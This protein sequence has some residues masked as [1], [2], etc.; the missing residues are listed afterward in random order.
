MYVF[1]SHFRLFPCKFLKIFS[2]FFLEAVLFFKFTSKIHLGRI[3]CL[4]WGKHQD[5]LLFHTTFQLT[6]YSLLTVSFVTVMPCSFC[7]NSSKHVSV[8]LF[9]GSTQLH[10]T[11]FLHL[12]QST[13]SNHYSFAIGLHLS[14]RAGLVF[15]QNRS[16][17]FVLQEKLG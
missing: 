13:L 15:W 10:W 1:V 2:P 3:F 11:G 12:H 16:S 7:H 5:S 6:Q 17:N 14:F 8:G 9:L 4:M